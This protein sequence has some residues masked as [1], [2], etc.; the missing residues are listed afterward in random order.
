MCMCIH[1]YIYIYIYIYIHICVYIYIYIYI[2]RERERERGVFKKKST[3]V[4]LEADKS[5][6]LQLAGGRPRR[7]D[8]IVPV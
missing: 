6:D 1:I 5:Q 7:A 4:I 3:C 8:G 2:V